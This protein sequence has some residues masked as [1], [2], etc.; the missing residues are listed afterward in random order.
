MNDA[1]K[2]REIWLA[3]HMV[4]LER[5]H[6]NMG[7]PVNSVDMITLNLWMPHKIYVLCGCLILWVT[8][9]TTI[10]NNIITVLTMDAK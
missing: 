10:Y 2:I 9:I 6:I 7:Q 3:E 1:I 8:F 5:G 4:E